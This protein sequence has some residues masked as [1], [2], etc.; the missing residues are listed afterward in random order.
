MTVWVNGN[1]LLS[2]SDS[3]LQKGGMEFVVQANGTV[4]IDDVEVWQY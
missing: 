2:S 3:Y 1:K 4:W